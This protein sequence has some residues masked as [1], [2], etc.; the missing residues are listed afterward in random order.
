MVHYD[1]EIL[2]QSKPRIGD[3]SDRRRFVNWSIARSALF[4]V[5]D[6]FALVVAH[7][8]AL[9]V[10]QRIIHLPMS[11]LNPSRYHL[12]Y[13][14]FFTLMFYLFEGY[15]NPESRRPERELELGC[16]ALFIGFVALSLFNFIVFHAEPVSRYLLFI[17]FAIAC[18][19]L[20][21]TRFTLRALNERLW[22]AGIG[23]RR[24]VLMGTWKGLAGYYRLLSIQRYYGYELLGLI[25]SERVTSDRAGNGPLAVLGSLEDWESIAT[26]LSAE[27]LVVAPSNFGCGDELIDSL[28]HRC[29]TIG[30][31]VELY[32]DALA[33]SN[34]NFERDHYSGCIRYYAR[35]EWSLI[36][37][38]GC[39]RLLDIGIGVTGSLAALLIIPIIGILIKLEDGG[40][41]FYRSAYLDQ[42]G[43]TKYYLKFR[44]MRVDADNILKT[45]EKL[46]AAFKVR[47]KLADDP[48]VTRIGKYLRKF[49]LDEF[50]QFFSILRGDLTFVGPRTIRADESSH[51]GVLAR[52]LLS[53]KPGVTGFWQTMGRQTTTYEER[54]QMD[55]F[56]IDHWSIWLDLVIAAKTIWKVLGTEGAY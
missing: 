25:T 30:I 41:I 38:R 12:Y 46:R 53:V 48:R 13:I 45:D 34:L 39:K 33:S 9:R 55:M 29:K 22:K 44:T 51:Y 14:P 1:T 20:L 40:P 23:K 4:L 36:L 2:P 5:G 24:T 3:A 27:V 49:S 26:G 18:V 42:S 43:N 54:V 35:P 56:Y 19:L 32:S 6:I 37:Q 52:K 15:R 31:D 10:T 11:S 17:W 7:M 8:L 47:Q 50:P 21:M 28:L 16:K